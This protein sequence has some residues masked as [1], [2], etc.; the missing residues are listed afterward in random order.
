MHLDLWTLALQ[1][2]NV[3]VLV[4]LL[5]R[6]LFRPVAG[7]IA[8]R[9]AAADA[10]LADAAAVRA[11][12]TTEAA[13]VAQQRQGLA[14]EGEQIVATTR[15]SAEAE[16]TAIMHQADDAIARQRHEAEQAIARDKLA[17]RDAL[18]HEATELALTIA[19]RLLERLPTQQLNRVFLEGLAGVLA[20]HPARRLLASAPIEI[21]SAAPLDAASQADCRTMLARVLG[22]APELSFRTDPTL[23][24][25]IELASSDVVIRN[26]WQSDLERI[27]HVLSTEAGHDVAVA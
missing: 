18:E 10:L 14:A 17:M 11:K 3:L 21:R 19:R 6:F 1:T 4:W 24:A 13:A 16:R 7:I 9:R 27:A 15:A 26:S 8:A 2:I 22:G 23:I 25:G 12:A 5:A 20:T